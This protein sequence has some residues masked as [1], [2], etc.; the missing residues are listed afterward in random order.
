[1]K[2]STLAALGLLV[3]TSTTQAQNAP[4]LPSPN[5]FLATSAFPISHSNP[6]ATET[7]AHAGPT[8]GRKLSAADVK[9]V[10]RTSSLPI[11]Q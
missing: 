2:K 8:K 7:V 5:P 4:N 6:G 10:P 1:M 3:A 11:Q 9:T